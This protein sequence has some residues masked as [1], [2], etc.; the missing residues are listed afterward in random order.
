MAGNRDQEL[1]QS[2]PCLQ[3]KK[4]RS[5]IRETNRREEENG[6]CVAVAT[7]GEIAAP[8]LSHLP[9]SAASQH[10]VPVQSTSYFHAWM[11][12]TRRRPSSLYER[13]PKL[14]SP[15]ATTQSCPYPQPLKPLTNVYFLPSY[16]HEGS[17]C[18]P[19][20]L[21][22]LFHNWWANLL[23]FCPQ[24]LIPHKIYVP[25]LPPT[26][27]NSCGASNLNMEWNNS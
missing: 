5:K 12:N 25:V 3:L 6:H 2:N 27:P 22:H 8:S 9:C 26:H 17:K 7:A 11:S 23:M 20:I 24:Q 19:T 16:P 13:L 4:R 1:S 15:A 10:Y 21:F 14:A 18:Q